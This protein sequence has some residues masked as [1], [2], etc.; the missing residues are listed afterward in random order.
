MS[1]I[2][3]WVNIVVAIIGVIGSVAVA[4]ITS[5]AR[6]DQKL[7]ISKNAIELLGQKLGSA[8]N[9]TQHLRRQ[10]DSIEK[11]QKNLDRRLAVAEPRFKT[12]LFTR[13]FKRS[14][15]PV[16]AFIETES[17]S[18]FV[19][20]TLKDGRVSNGNLTIWAAYRSY[21]GN[22]GILITIN[23]TAPLR[24]DYEISVNVYQKG[25]IE[26]HEPILYTGS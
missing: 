22:D 6:F 15:W 3:P 13:K 4:F 17:K 8:R 11:S 21:G 2:R 14:G 1:E 26:Y 23:S 10:L 12:I 5:G 24:D 19:L 18:P 7:E 9:E 20:A 16:R 25:A